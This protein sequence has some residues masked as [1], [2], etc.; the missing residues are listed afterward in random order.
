MTKVIFETPTILDLN[1]LTVFGLSAKPA[2]HNPIGY[3]GTGLKYAM[4]ILAREQCDVT[5]YIGLKEYKLQ[6]KD[7]GFRG[8]AFKSIEL[9]SGNEKIQL[10]FT[11]ELGKNWELW[12]AFRE[13]Y[14]NTIDENG[15][16]YIEDREIVPSDNKTIISVASDEFV[17]IFEDRYNQVFLEDADTISTSGVQIIAKESDYVYFRGIRVMKLDKLSL[18]TY[19]I[20]SHV[21]LTEDRTAAYEYSV[22]DTIQNALRLEANKDVLENALNCND[23]Y[24][25][26]E[27]HYSIYDDED[28]SNNFKEVATA[29]SNQVVKSAVYKVSSEYKEA[30]E[31]EK[32]DNRDAHFCSDLI[33]YLKN[34]LELDFAKIAVKN[35]EELIE[36]LEEHLD[37]EF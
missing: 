25:E 12:Q 23:N 13:L 17:D 28:T 10:P 29:C 4:A 11:T 9:V 14:C 36:I 1:A 3:F 21:T 20:L 35:K 32:Q 7:S 5:I 33:Y 16:S 31:Q 2:S 8:K 19:N 24:W 30:Q 18:N 6:V 27:F 22:K 34:D 26:S 15:S 37:C